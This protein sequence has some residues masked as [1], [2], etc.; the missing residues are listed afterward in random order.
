MIRDGSVLAKVWKPDLYIKKLVKMEVKESFMQM[1]GL[2]FDNKQKKVKFVS[3]VDLILNCVMTYKRF[4]HDQQSCSLKIYD[5]SG[6]YLKKNSLNMTTG[7]IKM[8][9]DGN[10]SPTED[11]YIF[12]ASFPTK[13]LIFHPDWQD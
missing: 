1:T 7:E 11:D 8:G 3:E 6:P 12:K 2:V 5:L 9:D 4:P 10:F 13:N